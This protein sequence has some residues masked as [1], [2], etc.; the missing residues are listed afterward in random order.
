[1]VLV[2]VRHCLDLPHFPSQRG[3]LV[4]RFDHRAEHLHRCHQLPDQH[5]LDLALTFLLLETPLHPLQMLSLT[6]HS[7]PGFRLRLG[8]DRRRLS[9]NPEPQSF[10]SRYWRTA[11]DHS[12]SLLVALNRGQGRRHIH[13][14]QPLEH[15]CQPHP[16]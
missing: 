6:L 15:V 4:L 1:M 7:G 5:R 8:R 2:L 9:L 3:R 14:L 12:M 16:A 13:A 11:F 10:L